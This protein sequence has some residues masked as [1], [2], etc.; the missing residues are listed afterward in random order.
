MEL[1]LDYKNFSNII[2]SNLFSKKG[3]ENFINNDAFVRKEKK[4]MMLSDK[5][6]K[7]DKVEEYIK[8]LNKKEA[9]NNFEKFIKDFGNAIYDSEKGY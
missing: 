5:Y 6:L 8:E 1:V 9:S 3:I 7:K 2:Q 4:L